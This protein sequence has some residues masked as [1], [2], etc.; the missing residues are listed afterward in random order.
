MADEE[1]RGTADPDQPVL[2]ESR[3]ER[4]RAAR[5]R[6]RLRRTPLILIVIGIVLV[7][8]VGAWQLYATLWMNHSRS[9]GNALIHH[10]LKDHSISA[11]LP[12]PTSKAPAPSRGPS[13]ALLAACNGPGNTA[14]GTG[15]TGGTAVHGLLEIPSLNVVAPIEQG[16]GD[17]VLAVAVGHD[18]YSVWP[19]KRGNAVL[20]AHDVSYFSTIDQLKSGDSIRYVTPCTT[21]SFTVTS[22]AIVTSGSPVYNTST[23]SL[24]LV[25]CWPTDALWFTPD[26]YLVTATEV[27]KGPSGNRQHAYL[28]VSNPPTVPVPAAL[29]S[30]GVTL[31]TYSLPM[32]TFTLA[33]SATPSWAHTTAPLLVDGS[34]VEAFI[35]GVRSLTENHLDWWDA[36]APGVK[37]PAP[38]VGAN[39]PGYET[40]TDVT[41]HAAGST[42]TAVTLTDTVTVSGGKHPGR[43]VMTVLTVVHGHT[44]TIAAWKMT[45]T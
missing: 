14:G 15:G 20:L 33:G 44:L 45:P 5:K 43:Y 25:T 31:A 37:P 1:V 41:E 38:L 32:G 3:A 27:S 21:Y 7:A 35:A 30:Q 18:P 11:P 12:S 22:H 28:T 34:G 13:S 36:I 26:R 8:A 17:G 9:A 19:G 39:N 24:T 16:T 42:A 10:F 4:R 29:V 2:V 23:P 6:R 40:A